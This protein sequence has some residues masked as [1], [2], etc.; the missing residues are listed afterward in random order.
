[1]TRPVV[2]T[3]STLHRPRQGRAPGGD[4]W[5]GDADEERSWPLGCG[6]SRDQ[7]RADTEQLVQRWGGPLGQARGGQDPAAEKRKLKEVA[8]Y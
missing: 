7:R 4:A 8:P 3:R 6:T 2:G 5:E 1:M